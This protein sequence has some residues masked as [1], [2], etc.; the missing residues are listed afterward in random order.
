MFLPNRWWSHLN[1]WLFL[2]NGWPTGIW[3][4]ELELEME[5]EPECYFNFNFYFIW[6]LIFLTRSNHSLVSVFKLTDKYT[7]ESGD[8]GPTQ[9]MVVIVCQRT[10]WISNNEHNIKSIRINLKQIEV[11]LYTQY[12]QSII[13]C[14]SSLRC[15]C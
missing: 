8:R 6:L 4:P 3:N 14:E 7:I 12:S 9:V 11:P 10:N 1:R 13:S 5:P 2:S 15:Y